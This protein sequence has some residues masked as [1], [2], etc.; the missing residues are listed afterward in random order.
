MMDEILKRITG[1]KVL[2][3]V[4]E[5]GREKE[6]AHRFPTHVLFIELKNRTKLPEA[7][8]RE[9]LEDLE[10]R[11]IIETGR[12]LNDIFIALRQ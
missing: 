7:D 11:E 2:A 3:V 10:E 9:V 5:I 8:L 6:E 4:G 12:T 1:T